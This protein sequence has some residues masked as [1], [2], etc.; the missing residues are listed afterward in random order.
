MGKDSNF[1]KIVKA[2]GLGEF[3]YKYPSTTLKK[4]EQNKTEGEMIHLATVIPLD[5]SKEEVEKCFHDLLKIKKERGVIRED[6]LLS[7]HS[8]IVRSKDDQ[9]LLEDFKEVLTVKQYEALLFANTIVK[10]ED[11]KV[12]KNVRK[13]QSRFE[14]V[15]GSMGRK[16]YNLLRSNY[17][18]DFFHFRLCMMKYEF[19]KSYSDKFRDFF[20]T[21]LKFFD[22]A[23]WSNETMTSKEIHKEISLRL[24][25][26][27]IRE[28]NIYGRGEHLTDLVELSCNNYIDTHER[29]W[30]EIK[31]YRLGNN[32][33]ICCT[34][35]KRAKDK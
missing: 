35:F 30:L 18:K 4:L 22:H 17:M 34:I 14:K 26:R 15:Y 10:L 6:L 31:R 28:V 2:C 20:S 8:L 21:Q 27:G 11:K 29:V 16:I 24:G 1:K 25:K 13:I 12:L 7:L 3:Q 5:F 33:A 23:I 19:E 32:R 9:K